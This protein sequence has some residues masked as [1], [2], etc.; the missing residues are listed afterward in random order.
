M[1]LWKRQSS[2]HCK[3]TVASSFWVQT[4]G[5]YYPQCTMVL[6]FRY[7]LFINKVHQFNTILFKWTKQ[8]SCKK[9]L[10]KPNTRQ[11]TFQS[12]FKN[13]SF[14]FL[15]TFCMDTWLES[16]QSKWAIC[17][18]FENLKVLSDLINKLFG[19]CN[20]IPIFFP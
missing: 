4:I 10:Y 5:K 3:C 18:P 19:I 9:T 8:N 11:R 15:A 2:P 1:F 14:P 12:K 6:N 7:R 16:D 13:K 17:Q 20:S